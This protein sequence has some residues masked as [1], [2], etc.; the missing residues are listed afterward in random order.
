MLRVAQTD[1]DSLVGWIAQRSPKGA[2]RWI[3]ALAAVV[4]DLARNPFEFGLA[5]EK[6]FR[7]DEVREV[8]FKTAHGNRYRL[9]FVVVGEEVR[10]L[11]V[12]AP[13]QRSLRLRDIAF[14]DPSPGDTDD[15]S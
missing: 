3:E 6:V 8:F 10:I 11:R 12:R 7:S 5:Y 15:L 1:M 13:G 9:L 2:E 14:D 4:A